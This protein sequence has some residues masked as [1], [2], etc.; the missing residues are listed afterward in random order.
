MA[1]GSLSLSS[2]KIFSYSF[3]EI[4]IGNR[5]LKTIRKKFQQEGGGNQSQQDRT[6]TSDHLN[7]VI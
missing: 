2:L 6:S 3:S 5:R 4:S 7:K 1:H